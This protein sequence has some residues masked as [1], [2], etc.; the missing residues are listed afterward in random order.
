MATATQTRAPLG[1]GPIRELADDAGQLL[2]RGAIAGLVAGGGFMLANM[3]YADA[4]GKPPVAPFLAI[5]TVFHASKAPVLTPQAMPIEVAT[6]LWL[7]IMLSLA[8]GMGFALLTPFLRRATLLCA[9]AIGYGL[10]LF[11]FN[12]EILGRTVFPF[13]TNPMGPDTVFE[14]FIHPL[15]FGLLLIPFFLGRRRHP[16]TAA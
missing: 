9:G 10:A 3:W 4:N 15:I 6:G 7:H 1:T 16:D 14:G 12:F 13:F 11:V 2:A 5:S 8:F